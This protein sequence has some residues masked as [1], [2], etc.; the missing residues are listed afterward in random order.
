[1]CSL[2][3]FLN[4]NH[5]DFDCGGYMFYCAL[6]LSLF[7]VTLFGMENKGA[8]LELCSY[9]KIYERPK[10][11]TTQKESGQSEAVVSKP[12][13]FCDSKILATNYVLLEDKDHD[14]R[15]MMNKF[16]YFDFDQGSHLLIMPI[17]HKEHPSEFS[18]KEL[19]EQVKTLKELAMKLYDNA[20]AQ[21][22][23]AS[24][25]AISGQSQPHWHGHLKNYVQLPMSL[26]EKM[27]SQKNTRIHTIEQAFNEVKVV[28]ESTKNSSLSSQIILYNG[29]E[30]DCCLVKD[31]Q[32]NDE[33]N[34]VVERFKH[35]Y[36]CLSHYPRWS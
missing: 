35:N 26:P 10:I 2:C 32:D 9:R 30:C 5:G 1:M 29:L 31:N 15:V 7:S 36:I 34:F 17:S 23:C 13:V 25:G 28:L 3:K 14:V 22:Y 18:H 27:K 6:L 21:E 4:N 33:N 19:A 20:Y 11:L 12:C 16:P 24:W 8:Q